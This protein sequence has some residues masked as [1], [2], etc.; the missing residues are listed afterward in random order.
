VKKVSSDA[1][2]A[3]LIDAQSVRKWLGDYQSALALVGTPAEAKRALTRIDLATEYVRQLKLSL[4]VE[5]EVVETAVFTEFVLGQTLVHAKK[6]GELHDG[7]PKK[8]VVIND[9]FSL[10]DAGITKDESAHAQRYVEYVEKFD[11]DSLREL[12]IEKKNRLKLS[13]SG[14]YKDIDQA[15]KRLEHEKNLEASEQTDQPTEG[16]FDIILAD[17]PWQYDEASTESRAIE[18]QY[19]TAT[20]AEIKEQVPDAAE[21]SV[22]FLWA[23]A[24]KL[25]EAYQVLFAWG[26]NYRTHAVWD[27]Q[28]IGMGYWFRGQ[29]E[30]LLVGTRGSF[31]PPPEFLRVSSIFTEKRS[32][33]STKPECVYQWIEKVWPKARKQEMYA[34][35]SRSGWS[36]WGKQA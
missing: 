8:T 11:L 31:P 2:L 3:S 14:V 10:K 15:L 5:M 22:L 30:L 6:A 19:P 35:K 23:T 13:R 32:S 20:L 12:V 36:T 7:R 1:S 17:P 4:T 27:K 28:I 33:H 18:N 21:E 16:P 34:R 25:F 9:R 26:F 24:P 29:H